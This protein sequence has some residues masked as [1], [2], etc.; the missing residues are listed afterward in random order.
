M[1]QST[2]ICKRRAKF[3]CPHHN[4]YL[5][6]SDAKEH[7][8]PLEE[9]TVFVK[10]T[11]KRKVELLSSLK[12]FQ[13]EQDNNAN[14]LIE[15]HRQMI[16]NLK[17]IKVNVVNNLDNMILCY[18]N[19]IK[20]LIQR[21]VRSSTDETMTKLKNLENDPDIL[22]QSNFL[23]NTVF[24]KL[25]K[26]ERGRFNQLK[27][28][29]NLDS[30]YTNLLRYLKSIER[31]AKGITDDLKIINMNCLSAAVKAKQSN[32]DSI[33][34]IIS[35][36]I[37][38]FFKLPKFIYKPE[39]KQELNKSLL[40]SDLK[41]TSFTERTSKFYTEKRGTELIAISPGFDLRR[42][43]TTKKTSRAT[44]LAFDIID[45]ENHFSLHSDS[46]ES[47]DDEIYSFCS[48]IEAT[49]TDTIV[50]NFEHSKKEFTRLIST[51]WNDL[52]MKQ[53]FDIEDKPK[54]N[55]RI[56]GFIEDYGKISQDML[57]NF[58]KI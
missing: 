29:L 38:Y 17:D 27:E 1:N 57:V 16:D 24:G 42:K 20:S 31:Q 9:I 52:M 36:E 13:D 40:N 5:C 7:K 51:L 26:Q 34:R 33:N 11:R 22:N 37:K 49:Y 23:N 53:F 2:C 41:K 55:M 6:P 25:R 12:R 4:V 28:L 14:N 54:V 48:H 10:K 3:I 8:C 45:E 47:S 15:T 30:V 39:T 32:Y 43:R 50:R 58:N 21:E 19:K 18:N 56:K 44:K 46:I 35:K